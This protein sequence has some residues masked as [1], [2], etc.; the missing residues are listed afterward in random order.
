[1]SNNDSA[2]KFSA[3][4]D[5]KLQF[6]YLKK[7][8]GKMTAI[9]GLPHDAS[10]LMQ[11][12]IERIK[13]QHGRRYFEQVLIDDKDNLSPLS[14]NDFTEPDYLKIRLNSLLV[15]ASS[16]HKYKFASKGLAGHHSAAGPLYPT[17]YWLLGN[18][19]A[20]N[21]T[22]IATYTFLDA[23]T[24]ID[25]DAIPFTDFIISDVEKEKLLSATR[26]V[27]CF[28]GVNVFT[29]ERWKNRDPV[30]WE[31]F[32]W[33]QTIEDAALLGA[34]KTGSENLLDVR[35]NLEW[36]HEKFIESELK[37]IMGKK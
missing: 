25:D 14:Y 36:L 20:V 16:D 28:H 37:N 22:I 19:F 7:V 21:P 31:C 30:K 32:Y 4:T 1:M 11:Q 3:Y 8:K 26:D 29:H 18:L 24:K 35:P 10:E 34:H 12:M 9:K 2:L 6:F 13:P 27:P 17:I 5:S 15:D 33:L 23:C